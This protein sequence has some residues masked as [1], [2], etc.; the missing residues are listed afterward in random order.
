MARMQTGHLT[1]RCKEEEAYRIRRAA[2]LNSQS[3]TGF[4]LAAALRH[5][6]LVEKIHQNSIDIRDRLGV[7]AHG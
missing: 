3:L 6:E 4:I 1:I 7:V 5:A 2:L